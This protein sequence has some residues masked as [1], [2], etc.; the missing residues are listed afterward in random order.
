MK[1]WGA[2]PPTDDML[3]T[4]PLSCARMWGRAALVMRMRPNTLTSK[5]I[6]SW[7]MELSAL[8]PDEPMPA[9]LTSTSMRPDRSSTSRTAPATDASS[10]TSSGRN[11]T[12]PRISPAAALRLVPYTVNPAPSSARAAASPMPADA[13]VT[14]ATRPVPI[15]IC[16]SFSRLRSSAARAGAGGD[17]PPAARDSPHLGSGCRGDRD[18]LAA[19]RGLGVLAGG[20]AG[21]Q[22]DRENRAADLLRRVDQ[23]RGQTG[24][25]RL[26]P[27]D[28][29]DRHRDERQAEADRRE[30]GREQDVADEAAVHVDLREP[31][32]PGGGD[33]QAGDEHGLEAEA[34][35]QWSARAG[36]ED[37]P[38]RE[39]QVR[40]AG[41]ERRVPE[42]VLHVQRDEEEHREQRGSDQDGGHVDAGDRAHPEDAGERHQRSGLAPLD[43]VEAGDQRQRDRAEAE[44]LRRVPAGAVGVDQRV[45][46]QRQAGG[47]RYGAGHVEVALARVARLGQQARREDGG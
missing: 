1:G 23:A 14:S 4:R 39:R 27:A 34:G 43:Q 22:H 26:N 25:V 2:N 16:H 29:R 38:D 10:V 30:Q 24:L 6:R 33:E 17:C 13:P 42:H 37:D 3:I 19:L 18:Q 12:P 41:L 40:E 36:G 8:A 7:A 31:D 45:H 47:D 11:T 44:R 21:H 32:K 20:A 35:D 5:T 28:R 9:L 15:D 46:E